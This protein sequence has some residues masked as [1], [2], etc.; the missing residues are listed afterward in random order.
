MDQSQQGVIPRSCLS[1]YPVKPRGPGPG[2]G[3]GP[4][5]PARA[6]DQQGR[7]R[8]GM[9]S[10]APA[11][12]SPASSVYPSEQF[13]TVATPDR[14]AAPTFIPYKPNSPAQQQPT[15]SPVLPYAQPQR[16]MSPG[17]YGGSYQKPTIAEG[18]RRSNS[19]GNIKSL[20]VV[21]SPQANVVPVRKPIGGLQ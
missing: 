15:N 19:H 5:S 18:R 16:S 13:Q 20:R 4:A 12:D 1:K 7:V 21:P 11:S 17:P 9:S 14:Q 6:A 2:A 8:E 10:P 3:T